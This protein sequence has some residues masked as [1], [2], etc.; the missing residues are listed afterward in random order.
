MGMGGN[1][2]ADEPEGSDLPAPLTPAESDLRDFPW[3]SLDVTRIFN[4]SFN[5][6][7]SRNPLAWMIGH[8]LWYRS[9]Q[10]V[11]AASL[12]DEDDELCYLAELGFDRVSWDS[13]REIALHGWIKCSDGRLYHPVVAEFARGAW[14]RK[15]QKR[16][17]TECARIKKHNQRHGTTVAFPDFND[18]V[19][20]GCAQTTL[21]APRPE[22]VPGSVPEKSR[23]TDKN[24]PRE[25]GSIGKERK[26][27]PN[28]TPNGVGAAKRGTRLPDDFAMPDDWIEAAIQRGFTR[29]AAQVESEK[30][31]LYWQAKSG[32]D[33]TKIDWR[34]TWLNWLL[35]ADKSRGR[36]VDASGKRYLGV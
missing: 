3:M 8:K 21:S 4:S 30:F 24:V 12:P 17:N 36:N 20:S 27:H 5:S 22:N 2:Q 14:G 32:R 6:R 23:G 13:V 25:K 9:W 16:Y 18:F 19:S 28:N 11:P 31:I 7:A 1:T 35:N 29:A 15:L 33:A 34:K 26:G 10:Q